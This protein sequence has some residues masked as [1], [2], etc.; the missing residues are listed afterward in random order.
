MPIL[1]CGVEIGSEVVDVRILIDSGSSLDLIPGT[2]ARKFRRKACEVRT[3]RKGVRMKVANGKKST[4]RE[5]MPLRLRFDNETAELTD[6]LT[7]DDLP[8]DFIL[9][10][11]T[12]RKWKG[13]IDWEKNV[14]SI[15][16]GPQSKRLTM[17]WNVYCG[18]H[19][20]KPA[21][22]VTAEDILI[23]PESQKIL[24]IERVDDDQLIGATSKKGLV[25][26]L[27]TATVMKNKFCVAYEYGEDIDKVIAT[28]PTNVMIKIRK[29]TSG[30]ISCETRGSI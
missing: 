29:G 18:Q 30:R 28:N 11:E 22:L 15:T 21:T 3:I 20:R 27:R 2:L 7:L 25:S 12:L 8:F 10:N 5:V 26:P 13:I 4:V 14:V 16:P 1:K 19:W 9:G 17:D 24:M 6:F 23:P